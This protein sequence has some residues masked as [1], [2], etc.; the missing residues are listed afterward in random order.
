VVLGQFPGFGV[1]TGKKSKNAKARELPQYHN[2]RLVSSIHF[3]FNLDCNYWKKFSKTRPSHDN[4]RLL[5]RKENSEVDESN[6]T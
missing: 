6:T 1:S 4:E 3:L 2:W 5:K